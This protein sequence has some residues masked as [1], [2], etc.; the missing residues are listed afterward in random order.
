MSTFQIIKSIHRKLTAVR[1]TASL[2]IVATA[3]DRSTAVTVAIVGTVIATPAAA[4]A[5][6]S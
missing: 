2:R 5:A 1:T 4:T 6:A 3:S